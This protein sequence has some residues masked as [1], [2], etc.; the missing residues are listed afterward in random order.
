MAKQWNPSPLNGGIDCSAAQSGPR[1]LRG[2]GEG[3]HGL[4]AD[5]GAA[6]GG[7]KPGLV[8]VAKLQVI[9]T[10]A[11]PADLQAV[12][13]ELNA[14]PAA[15]GLDTP[16]RLAHFFAQ[17]REEAGPALQ[18]KI[19]SLNYAADRLPQIFGYYGKHPDEAK[20]DGYI[21]DASGK[22][23]QSANEQAIANKAYANRIGNGD[24]ASGDGW[25]FRG[26][27]F[28]QVTG[29]SN[30]TAITTQYKKTYPGS[31]TDFLNDP[32]AMAQFPHIVR[33]AV[34]FWLWKKLPA[35]ADKGEADAN[36]NAITEQVNSAT[37]S[38][39]NR[40]ANFKTARG[41]FK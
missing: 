22:L 4:M 40:C 13:N 8:T 32:D 41:V 28:I 36:V 5:G 14:N 15:Y 27:G 24:V 2:D 21:K 17:V 1:R 19:E 38:Y 31:T 23:V 18:G 26:R 11:K 25:K 33:S 3:W 39:A 35:L 34:C 10:K 7:A 12:A 37:D 9:F 29:R 6:A 16:L 20:K 30:Y